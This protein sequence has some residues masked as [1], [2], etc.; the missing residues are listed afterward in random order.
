MFSCGAY[1]PVIDLVRRIP[2]IQDSLVKKKTTGICPPTTAYRHYE[3]RYNV[4]LDS[5]CFPASQTRGWVP[6]THERCR[7]IPAL[8]GKD[9][10]EL[11]QEMHPTPTVLCCLTWPA[12]F[13]G[14]SKYLSGHDGYIEPSDSSIARL[15][16]Q[17]GAIST[18]KQGPA[19][20]RWGN[21]LRQSYLVS[22]RWNERGLHV[23]NSGDADVAI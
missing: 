6:K 17:C 20:C 4:R 15:A 9:R 11:V 18:S 7:R 13:E 10:E 3:V 16:Q 5:K 19:P 14:L 8:V 22:R 12:N 21:V 23:A 2:T 1:W